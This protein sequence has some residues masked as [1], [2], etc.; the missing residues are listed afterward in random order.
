[1]RQIARALALLVLL[2]APA[3][4]LADAVALELRPEV[5]L[6][7]SAV[8]LGDLAAVT[9]DDAAV[10]RLF[11]QAVVGKA[12]LAGYV[13]QR[14]RADLEM[15]LRGQALAVGQTIV[16]RGAE[17][18]RLRIESQRLD[19]DA[20][21]DAA[22]QQ[23][24]AAHGAAYERLELTLAAPLPV[25]L[26]PTGVLVYR[27]R[28]ADTPRLRSRTAVW[29]DVLVQDVVYR[30]VVVPLTVRAY[31]QVPACTNRPVF[32]RSP[33]TCARAGWAT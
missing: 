8:T 31:R 12:P 32:S 6:T 26:A 9:A 5:L 13:D 23:V 11:E 15:T 4:A 33:R 25:L 28:A 18:V 22:R 3:P 1:M 16:W 20:L 21:L 24:L 30:S 7:R 2:P 27:G 29:V 14:S 19:E 10:R 17:R